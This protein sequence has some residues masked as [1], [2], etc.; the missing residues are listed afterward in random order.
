MHSRLRNQMDVVGCEIE[1]WESRHRLIA[2]RI[3]ESDAKPHRT[4]KALRAKSKRAFLFRE[5]WS[6]HASSRRFST[7]LHCVN[8]N[9]PFRNDEEAGGLRDYFHRLAWRVSE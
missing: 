9:S 3:Y 6:A 4:P 7:L 8:I 5:A 1:P 2:K